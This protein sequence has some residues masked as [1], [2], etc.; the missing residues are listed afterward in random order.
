[1]TLIDR[2]CAGTLFIVA[3]LECM[4]VPKTYVGRIWIFGTGL[5]LLFTAML[6][7]LRIRNGAGVRGLRLF[8][9]AANSTMLMLAIALMMSIGRSR[10]LA[11]PHIPV[12]GVMLLLET[13]FSL[14]KRA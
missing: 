11:N 4:L 14:R 1:M 12:I 3:I 10:T 5:A 9:I 8:C 13:V 2:L 6:N 7:L